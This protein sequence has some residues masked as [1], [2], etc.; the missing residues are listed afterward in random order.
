MAASKKKKQVKFASLPLEERQVRQAQDVE[1]I[2]N[3]KPSWLFNRFDDSG[4]WSYLTD[5]F[6][7]NFWNSIYPKLKSFET[8]KWCDILQTS[9]KQNHS[10]PIC[11]LNNCAQERLVEL[12]L[13]YDD[14]ISLRLDGTTRIYG[15]LVESSLLILWC[16][17][18]H[19]DNSTCV[20]RSNKKYT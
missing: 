15:F 19:G 10:I 9:K 2:W 17:F 5:E 11:E 18:H 6:K 4:N 1:S 16:D 14:I 7:N 12:K 20:C 13:Y 8:M 3:K